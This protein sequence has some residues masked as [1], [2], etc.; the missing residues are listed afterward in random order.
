MRLIKTTDCFLFL[1]LC[2]L[3]AA[4]A[5]SVTAN[6]SQVEL[7]GNQSE[8]EEIFWG[9]LEKP[10]QRAADVL[11]KYQ[12]QLDEMQDGDPEG[13]ALL[14]KIQA[15]LYSLPVN[16]AL[17]GKKVMLGGYIAPL[18]VDNENG[19]VKEFLLVPYFGACIH[20]PPPPLN[21]ILLVRP[22]KGKSIHMQDIDEPVWV[23]G[24][25]ST[26]NTSTALAE[27]GYQMQNARVELMPP[28]TE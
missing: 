15:E 6:S 18:E 5:F 20:V 2:S 13:M 28:M 21:Q 14:E 24:T 9:D 8:Y 17:N 7:P 1:L 25:I 19:M 27:A 16:P 12:P 10:D 22:Q 26:E 3:I 4:P 23:F 11:E